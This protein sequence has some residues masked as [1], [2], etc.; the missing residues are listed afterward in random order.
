M[1]PMSDP[2]EGRSAFGDQDD[3]ESTDAR[4]AELD[5]LRIRRISQSKRSCHRAHSY[6]L[7]GGFA[8]VV[9]FAQLIYLIISRVQNS[10][11]SSAV[12]AYALMIPLSVW[13]ALFFFRRAGKY[14]VEAESNR[15]N[16]PAMPPDFSTLSDGS[17]RWDNFDRIQ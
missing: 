17:Q 7:I 10:G 13:S 2:N 16:D 12:V 11:V 14:K 15:L 1:D 9:I 4:D 3:A 8:C 5:G 6:A